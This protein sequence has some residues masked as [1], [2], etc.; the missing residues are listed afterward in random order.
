MKGRL[1]L[2]VSLKIEFWVFLVAPAGFSVLDGFNQLW[3][4]VHS[5]E[6]KGLQSETRTTGLPR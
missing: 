2:L 1:G 4:G 5:L 3:M 6:S